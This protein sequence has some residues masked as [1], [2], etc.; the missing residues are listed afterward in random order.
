MLRSALQASPLC[1]PV[2]Q[3]AD[4]LRY[5]TASLETSPIAHHH[6]T[7]SAVSVVIQH[8]GLTAPPPHN[9]R[10]LC[11]H[12]APWFDSRYHHTTSAVSVVIQHRGLTAGITRLVGNVVSWSWSYGHTGTDDDRHRSVQAVRNRFQL[13]GTGSSCTEL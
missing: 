3:N 8:R 4:C 7:T 11:G 6:H 2:Y 1:H 9:I 12:P 13:S 10:R 5:M